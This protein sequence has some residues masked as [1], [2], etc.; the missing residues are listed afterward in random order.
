MNH[1]EV[2]VKSEFAPLRKVVLTQSEFI[3]PNRPM[4]TDELEILTEEN[5]ELYKNVSGKNYKDAFPKEQKKW[6]EERENLK[7]VLEK[8]NVEVIRPRLLTEYEKEINKEFGCS[9]FFVRDPF[10]TVGNI[11]IEGSLRYFH[12][13]NEIFPIRSIIENIS[14]QNNNLYVSVPRPDTSEGMESEKGP[15]LEGGDVLVLDRTIFVGKSGQASNDNGYNWLKNLLSHFGYNVIQVPLKKEV[16]HLDCALSIVRDGLIIVCEEA[17]LNGIPKKLESWDKILVPYSDVARLAVNGL[18]INE[19]VYILD[20]E[21][22]Y[23][24]EQLEQRGIKTEYIDFSISRS[25]GGSF[26]CSTQPISRY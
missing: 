15:F 17:L 3:F 12:R 4:N 13:R 6:N 23:I 20:P 5:I 14:H 19:H 21:F 1:K 10:F 18:P 26:R 8:Y 22:K 9:N 7:K 25:L 2:M 24:G 11:I 16:L